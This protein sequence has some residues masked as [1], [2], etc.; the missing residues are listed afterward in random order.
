[1]KRPETSKTTEPGVA[2]AIKYDRSNNRRLNAGFLGRGT[3]EVAHESIRLTGKQSRPFWFGLKTGIELKLNRM[4]NVDRVGK[5]IRF[6]IEGASKD[7]QPR[8]FSFRVATEAQAQ[9]IESVLP[10]KRTRDFVLEKA[11]RAK[12]LAATPKY[13]VVPAIVGLNLL[14]F[15]L[16]CATGDGIFGGKPGTLTRWGANLGTLSLNGQWWRLV[17]SSFLHIG[18]LHLLMNMAALCLCGVLVERLYGNAAFALLYLAAGL[19]GSLASAFCHPD[20]PS[21]GASDAVFGVYGALLAYLLRQKG[22]VPPTTLKQ[23][24]NLCIIFVGYNLFYGVTEAGIDTAAH[25]GGLIGGF[26]FGLITAQSLDAR[27]KSAHAEYRLPA[28][29]HLVKSACPS[30]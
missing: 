1:M 11:F 12:L 8:Q 29:V 10:K 18:A 30:R 20:V 16:A 28:G 2:V 23:L 22:T 4:A 9:Q 15:I 21:V 27:I 5:R 19:S 26:L 6:V 24:Q 13:Y 7:E 3:I 17:T 14:V 25:V